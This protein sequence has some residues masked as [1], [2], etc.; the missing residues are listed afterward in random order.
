MARQ[1]LGSN[2][3][4]LTDTKVQHEATRHCSTRAENVSDHTLHT[5][6]TTEKGNRKKLY[7]VKAIVQKCTK[8]NITSLM[9][10]H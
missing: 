8:E 5:Y 3:K 9:I 2:R 6:F 4:L 1:V 7:T 10:K